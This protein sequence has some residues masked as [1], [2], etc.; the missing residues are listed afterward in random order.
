M[1]TVMRNVPIYQYVHLPTLT[2]GHELW[3]VTI[4]TRLDETSFLFR[5]AGSNLRDP[6]GASSCC[7]FERSQLR[8]FRSSVQE[9]Y[10]LPPIGGFSG[11]VQLVGDPEV[12]PE[13]AGEITYLIWP[14]NAKP[15]FFNAT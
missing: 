10:W 8:W 4:I 13:H 15:V 1:R 3:L 11:H 5:V 6:E 14:G 12:D 2:D 9:A 7:S